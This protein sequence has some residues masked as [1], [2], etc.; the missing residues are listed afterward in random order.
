M[1]KPFKKLRIYCW[2]ERKGNDNGSYHAIGWRFNRIR[3]SAIILTIAGY[4][5]SLRV[6]RD[7][8]SNELYVYVP[9]YRSK[10]VSPLGWTW[11]IRVFVFLAC[12]ESTCSRNVAS[13]FTNP[14]IVRAVFAEINRGLDYGFPQLSNFIFSNYSILSKYSAQT[15]VMQPVPS[16]A[17]L[18]TTWSPVRNSLTFTLWNQ[19]WEN[20][21]I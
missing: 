10:K 8:N 9:E 11:V 14:W 5:W 1:R 16:F 21:H 4:L 19:S 20:N 7:K 15:S 6:I 2:F 13:F 18:A 3:R 17:P 12:V